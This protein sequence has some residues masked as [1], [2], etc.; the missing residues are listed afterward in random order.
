MKP[1]VTSSLAALAL[2]VLAHAAMAAD[3]PSAF[4][5]F[6]VIYYHEHP[7]VEGL[8]EGAKAVILA[9]VRE[10]NLAGRPFLEGRIPEQ[11]G[12]TGEGGTLLLDASRI[13]LIYG[14]DSAKSAEVL[15][16]LA[17]RGNWSVVREDHGSGP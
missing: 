17:R 3:G 1:D 15:I 11:L 10:V 4:R 13:F 7:P 2:T 8:Q 5:A 16:D 9:D 12:I 14:T 6:S